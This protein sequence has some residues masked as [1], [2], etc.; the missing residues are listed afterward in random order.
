MKRTMFIMLTALLM[1]ASVGCVDSVNPSGPGADDGLRDLTV[2]DITLD[3]PGDLNMFLSVPVA[4]PLGI[5]VYIAEPI[6]ATPAELAAEVAYV[7]YSSSNP[8]AASVD[9]NGVITANNLGVTTIT[10]R[11]AATDNP[12]FEFVDTVQI[13]VQN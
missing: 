5:L 3:A 6:I 4:I 1:L 11:A 7:N 12:G 8:S 2:T 10:M 9:V 13:T